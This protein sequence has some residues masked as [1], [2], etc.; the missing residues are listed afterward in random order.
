VRVGPTA[1][2]ASVSND[3]DGPAA[4][5]QLASNEASTSAGFSTAELLALL[6]VVWLAGVLF[7][8]AVVAPRRRR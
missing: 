4:L 8:A 7:V 5:A 1:L 3:P 6:A 2:A